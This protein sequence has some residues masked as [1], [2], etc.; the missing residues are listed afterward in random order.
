MTIG[1]GL[2][3]HKQQSLQLNYSVAEMMRQERNRLIE[4]KIRARM[5]ELEELLKMRE[6]CPGFFKVQPHSGY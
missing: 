3:S 2:L 6:T 1:E 4:Q 5:V